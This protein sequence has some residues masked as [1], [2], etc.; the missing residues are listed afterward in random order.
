MSRFGFRK[1]IKSFLGVGSITPEYKTCTITYI[2]PDGKE[3]VVEVE[4]RHRVNGFTESSFSNSTGRR[5]SGS[6]PDGQCG[7]RIEI[8]DATGL[9]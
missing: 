1:K 2:I 5:A 6:C 8:D 7:L 4:E 9:N 3:Q